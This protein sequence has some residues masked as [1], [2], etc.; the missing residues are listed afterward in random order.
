MKI[1]PRLTIALVVPLLALTAVIGVVYERRSQDLLREEL[2]KEGRAIAL[3]VRIATE[4]Y[5]RDRQESDLKEL[6]ERLS[7]YERVLGLRLFDAQGRLTYQSRSLDPY[8]FRHTTQLRRVLNERRL[9]E[10]RRQFGRETAV[11]FIVPLVDRNHE[12]MGAVQVLQL[13]SYIHQDSTDTLQFIVLLM[14]FMALLIVAIVWFV[15][16]ANISRPATELVA[17]FQEVGAQ[18]MPTAVP[19]RRDDE[20]GMLASEFNSMCG[21]LQAARL[22]L[23]AA[24]DH[25]R[26]IE[27]RLRNAERLAGL[28]R[29]AAGLAHE[30]GTPLNVISGRAE[31][32]MRE[33]GADPVAGK[34]LRIITSQTDRIVRIV[35]DMLDFARKKPPRRM[36]VEVEEVIQSVLELLE[37]RLINRNVRVER[38]VGEDLP[39]VV[40]DPDQLQQVF[41]NLI[42]N[43]LDAMPGGGRLGI[44]VQPRSL[45]HPARGGGPIECVRVSFEDDGTGIAPDD[46]DHVF[47]PFFT[48][49][50][51]GQG[52]GL[53]LSVSYGIVEEHGGWFDL[54]SRPGEGTRITVVLPAN[55]ESAQ[56]A[57]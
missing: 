12:L 53:G 4:D 21:R 13:E 54:D 10:T 37:Q 16:R 32:M 34:H 50:E 28:G 51:A 14:M 42:M 47:D 15:A 26:H 27:A 22:S 1:G 25:R 17:S 52:T 57:A 6:I 39:P 5:L 44:S 3:V 55:R 43:A 40:A 9:M 38:E 41:L 33:H 46:H 31:S 24:H 49:K 11:G 45:A 8:P 48:T 23:D 18:G 35:R 2:N 29:L 7:G 20:F 36:R 56:G 30:I 19:V